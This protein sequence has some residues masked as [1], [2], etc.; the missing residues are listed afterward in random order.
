MPGAVDI[1]GIANAGGT[2]TVNGQSTYR[3]NEYFHKALTIDNSAGAVWQSVTISATGATPQS[4]HVYLPRTPED[5]D[6]PATPAV[7]EGYDAD[8][9]QL[10]DG[11]WSYRW[12][13]ENRLIAMESLPAVPDAA[14]M[15][16]EFAYDYRGR[17]IEKKVFV[18]NNATLD[19][20]LSTIRRYLYDGWNLIAILDPQS[21]ILQ[22][23]H[24]SGDSLLCCG[25]HPRED[26]GRGFAD[27]TARVL[28]Q[29]HNL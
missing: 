9:N 29:R 24:Q 5:F 8:G 23:F 27:A 20:Q 2:V 15:R 26:A 6:D 25:A 1:L 18:W 14:K 7:N 21:S 4:G 3:R 28:Q 11:R 16:L 22:S 13:A 19:Y 12:D 10:R 17:R